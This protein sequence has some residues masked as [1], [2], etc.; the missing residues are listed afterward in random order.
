MI[1]E[2]HT[3]V[4]LKEAIELLNVKKGERYIDATLGGGGHSEAIIK[5]GGEVLGI[6]RDPEALEFSGKRLSQACPL[7]AFRW[8]LIEGNFGQISDL[9]KK[10]GFDQVKGILFDLGVS[11]HQLETGERGFSFNKEAD[12][13]MRM[14]PGLKVTAKDLVNGLNEGELVELFTKLGGEH[15]S[16]SIAAA[17]CR[18]RKI[19]PIEKCDQ[20]ATIILR[21]VPARGKYDRTHPAT[22]VF[23]ALRIAVNDELN[24]LK[25]ALPSALSLLKPGGR[26]VAI[27]FHSLEDRIVKDFIKE[28]EN[29]GEI[30]NLTGSPITP[31]RE[32]V[33]AN[34]RARSAKMRGAEKK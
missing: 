15:R 20:L 13:D 14:S 21:S 9:A 33:E 10:A 7:G 6:D 16:R 8:T 34:P 28:K 2:Y 5:A 31:S 19:S 1:N 29:S 26:L 4:L 23:Q 32:E 11:S 30:I 12:L 22:R 24:N 3:P 27:S 25:E 17:I 18:A